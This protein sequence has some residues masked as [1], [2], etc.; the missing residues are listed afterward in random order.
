MIQGYGDKFTYE[1]IATPMLTPGTTTEHHFRTNEHFDFL[2]GLIADI[3]LNHFDEL[4]TNK[5]IIGIKQ[6]NKFLINPVPLSLFLSFNNV[7]FIENFVRFNALAKGERFTLVITNNA[8]FNLDL[9]FIA[10]LENKKYEQTYQYDYQNIQPNFGIETR[11]N[12][13]NK[14]KRIDQ[15][16]ILPTIK[17]ARTYFFIKDRNIYFLNKASYRIFSNIQ[18]QPFANKLISVDMPV[19]ELFFISHDPPLPTILEINLL[20]RY[21][22]KDNIGIQ[23]KQ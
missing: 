12:I 1:S 22:Q 5:I 15:I 19:T 7:N 17:P 8:N 23:T 4:D 13:N 21:I 6:R 16:I 2:T 3:D 18:R 20:Y 11:L 10:L 9:K 14:C